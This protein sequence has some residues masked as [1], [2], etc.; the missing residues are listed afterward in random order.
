MIS[1]VLEKTGSTVQA[2]GMLYKSE[3]QTVILYGRESWVVREE[4]MEVLEGFHHWAARRIVGMTD[5]CTENGEW[6]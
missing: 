2:C 6:E 3:A 1:K 4:I 5:W